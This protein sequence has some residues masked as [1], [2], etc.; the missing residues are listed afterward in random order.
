MRSANAAGEASSEI[1]RSE[2]TEPPAYLGS[3]HASLDW[4]NRKVL[5]I[6]PAAPTTGGLRQSPCHVYRMPIRERLVVP[7]DFSPG[8]LRT[9]VYAASL[10]SLIQSELIFVHAL[11]HGWRL[12]L[13]E[14]AIRDRLMSIYGGMSHLLIREG[15][16]SS[17]VLATAG[18]EAATAVLLAP[19]GRRISPAG[20]LL[21]RSMAARLLWRAAC[22]VLM[23]GN[24]LIG[25]PAKPLQTILCVLEP[26]PGA[27]S[28]L[29]WSVHLASRHGADLRIV[30]KEVG[31]AIKFPFSPCRLKRA[32]A[33]LN[34]LSFDGP[35]G[36]N[37]AAGVNSELFALARQVRADLLVIGRGPR[38]WPFGA[39]RALAPHMGRIAPCPVAIV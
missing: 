10:A 38:L 7:V 16:T 35:S 30:K 27:T 34:G 19:S 2:D 32:P 23:V 5:E 31:P 13:H 12:K 39:L 6:T 26:G 28:V 11:Q 20:L 4:G 3:G 8:S 29:D 33:Q 18:E 1:S 15:S 22:P 36:A 14:L 9:A 25:L 24:G 21:E 17:V 37:L